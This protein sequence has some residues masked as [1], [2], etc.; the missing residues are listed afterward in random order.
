MS[1]R[2]DGNFD[3]AVNIIEPGKYMGRI[4][5]VEEKISK[6]PDHKAYWQVEITLTQEPFIGRKVWT[7]VML[8]ANSLW[9]LRQLAEAC[10]L[11]MTGRMD[12][13]SSELEGQELGVALV[14]ETYEG[15]ERTK[16]QSFF[17]L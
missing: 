9:K 17:Q 1:P 5:K 14:A 11:D 4:D 2:I 3:E 15:K 8:Q 12:F 7:N 16:V 10:G 6:Q 13:D